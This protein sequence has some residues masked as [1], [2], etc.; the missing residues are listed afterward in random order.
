MKHCKYAQPVHPPP[1]IIRQEDGGVEVQEREPLYV[2]CLRN[3]RPNF[4]KRCLSPEHC[5]YYAP[6]VQYAEDGLRRLILTIVRYAI[7]ARQWDVALWW[8]EAYGAD[9]YQ[10]AQWLDQRR[11]SRLAWDWDT[12]HL[13]LDVADHPRCI[14]G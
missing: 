4:T 2:G 7:A 3:A 14:R 5:L 10:A 8:C 11:R 1:L 13:H 9:I 6:L 12:P